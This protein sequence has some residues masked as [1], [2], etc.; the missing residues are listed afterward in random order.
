MMLKIWSLLNGKKRTIALIYWAVLVPSMTVL[1]P[2]GYTDGFPLVFSKCVT[3][4]G[5]FLSALG[6]GHAAVK[7]KNAKRNSEEEVDE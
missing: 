5:F 3:I 2:H 7:S 1:W 6:L 4:F